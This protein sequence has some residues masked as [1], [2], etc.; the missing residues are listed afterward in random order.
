M[1]KKIGCARENRMLLV[2][3]GL[4]DHP[5]PNPGSSNRDKIMH[6]SK[7]NWLSAPALY[8]NPRES[9]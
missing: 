3:E 4:R 5:I 2:D 9:L 6:K 8:Q 7:A 1:P